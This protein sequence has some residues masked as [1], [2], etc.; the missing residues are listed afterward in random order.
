MQQA[1]E[2]L[3]IQ[4][5]KLFFAFKGFTWSSSINEIKIVCRNEIEKCIYRIFDLYTTARR[6]N[7]LC[8]TGQ[9]NQE[10]T[11]GKTGFW[12]SKMKFGSGNHGFD[13]TTKAC[14]K[15]YLS[16]GYI[17]PLALTAHV[18]SETGSLMSYYDGRGLHSKLRELTNFIF[19]S[20][21]KA[22]V[23]L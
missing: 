16:T 2:L 7:G 20:T 11:F 9:T 5:F 8:L 14:G 1:S 4:T 13:T 3:S 15:L 17:P 21:P 22:R 10:V 18:I 19:Q 6:E 12:R 23:V